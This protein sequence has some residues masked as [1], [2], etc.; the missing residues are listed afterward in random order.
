[1]RVEPPVIRIVMVMIVKKI[2]NELGCRYGGH[3]TRRC[4][5]Q[6]TTSKLNPFLIWNISR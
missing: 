4:H 1:M 3:T 6:L 5:L 2:E